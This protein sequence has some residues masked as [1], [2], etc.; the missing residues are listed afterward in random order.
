MVT[1]CAL[2]VVNLDERSQP[3][4]EYFAVAFG[5]LAEAA[6]RNASGAM[7]RA[8]KVGKISE[9][10]IERDI[11]NRAPVICEQA[12]GTAHPR[13][14]EILVRRD[15]NDLAEEAQEMERAQ[16]DFTRRAVEVDRFLGVRIDP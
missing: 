3:I 11:G 1:S 13:A 9:P 6:R 16:A 5:G 7:E 10:D 4:L 8:Y 15:A 14:H 2:E 12:R